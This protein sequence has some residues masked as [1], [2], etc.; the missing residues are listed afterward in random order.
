MSHVAA[1]PESPRRSFWRLPRGA[2]ALRRKPKA[3]GGP[4]PPSPPEKTFF[5]NCFQRER[6]SY[7]RHSLIRGEREDGHSGMTPGS[8][9]PEI[10]QGRREEPGRSS[11]R[12]TLRP[13][14]D[15]GPQ[16]PR[17]PGPRQSPRDSRWS[18]ASAP[19]GGCLSVLAGGCWLSS[20][21]RVYLFGE[22]GGIL[23]KNTRVSGINSC[24]PCMPPPRPRICGL[25]S[26]SQTRPGFS[27]GLTHLT[28]HLSGSS[29][30]LL[31]GTFG[32]I[33]QHDPC[34]CRGDAEAGEES[35]SPERK[36]TN[37][38]TPS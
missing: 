20:L 24:L 23:W 12:S 34:L 29:P 4:F 14:V 11:P 2:D 36:S 3:A 38:G 35:P 18:S 33:H 16:S 8:S 13:E 28:P 31:D 37:R 7:C 22:G 6:R 15:R 17:R 32:L 21:P 30:V 25:R 1:G 5:S 27:A 9:S 10:L 19:G 26:V